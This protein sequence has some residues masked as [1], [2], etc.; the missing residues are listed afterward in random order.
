MFLTFLFRSAPE[1][2]LSEGEPKCLYG[3]KLARLGGYGDP[4]IEKG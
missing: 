3:E 4:T 1:E 2:G